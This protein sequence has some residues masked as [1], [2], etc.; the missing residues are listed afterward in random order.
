MFKLILCTGIVLFNLFNHMFFIVQ[1]MYDLVIKEHLLIKN[2]MGN[3]SKII[4]FLKKIILGHNKIS[5]MTEGFVQS[6]R[7]RPVTDTLRMIINLVT[8]ILLLFTNIMVLLKIIVD[9]IYITNISNITVFNSINPGGA[10]LSNLCYLILYYISYIIGPNTHFFRDIT[11]TVYCLKIL[12]KILCTSAYVNS[13]FFNYYNRL[14]FDNMSSPTS[15]L[16]LVLYELKITNNIIK[17]YVSDP[18]IISYF[19][20]PNMKISGNLYCLIVIGIIY[21]YEKY[22]KLN[23]ASM[24]MAKMILSCVDIIPDSFYV[25]ELIFFNW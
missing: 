5:D 18:M 24:D 15:V 17:L 8:D 12:S 14:P 1:N 7:T 22:L 11:I 16:D 6:Q 20:L 10:N 2:N 4:I 21:I 9:Y 19:H 25:Y 13:A 23:Y 3:S